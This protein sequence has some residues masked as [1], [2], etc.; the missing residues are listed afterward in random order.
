[1]DILGSLL[2]LIESLA[3][4]DLGLSPSYAA[5]KIGGFEAQRVARR[6]MGVV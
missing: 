3:P 4:A 2:S 6:Y 1:L 5:G